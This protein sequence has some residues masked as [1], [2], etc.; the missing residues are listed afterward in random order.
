M[1]E[2]GLKFWMMGRKVAFGLLMRADVSSVRLMKAEDAV[3]INSSGESI[4]RIR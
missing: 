2:K 3:D 4:C 1:T